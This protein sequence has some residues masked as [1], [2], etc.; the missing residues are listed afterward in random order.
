M[1]AKGTAPPSRG[2]DIIETR[3]VYM[4]TDIVGVNRTVYNKEVSTVE[5]PFMRG[6]T[7]LWLVC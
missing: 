4:A 7:A 3:N 5:V 1:K 6:L 2:L